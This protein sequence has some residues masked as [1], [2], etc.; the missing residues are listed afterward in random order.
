MFLDSLKKLLGDG[1]LVLVCTEQA[2]WENY[3]KPRPMKYGAYRWAT[4]ANV[5]IIPMF[6]GHTEK[7]DFF[8]RKLIIKSWR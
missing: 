5:P 7:S 6:V 8:L 2:M 4:E 3:Q 1:N